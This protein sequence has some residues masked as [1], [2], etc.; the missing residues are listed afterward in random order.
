MATYRSYLLNNGELE[1]L[2]NPV[3]NLPRLY[4]KYY[5]VVIR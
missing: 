5:R 4:N 1:Y 3:H 2:S